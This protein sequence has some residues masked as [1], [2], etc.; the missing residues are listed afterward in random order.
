V[1]PI[2]HHGCGDIQPV[3]GDLADMRVT[4]L[5][6]PQAM[7]PR[8]PIRAAHG[9]R[10]AIYGETDCQ[11]VMLVGMP[12]EVCAE[13][14][15]AICASGTGRSH[16]QPHSH[17]DFRDGAREYLDALGSGARGAGRVGLVLHLTL[18]GSHAPGK[19][20]ASAR[21]IERWVR[22]WVITICL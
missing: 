22:A 2:M 9:H 3:I 15:D 18:D 16:H 21:T 17:A 10:L 8:G 6:A 12:D 14:R 1:L 5:H 20:S 13:T 7:M 4:P 19:E 11:G